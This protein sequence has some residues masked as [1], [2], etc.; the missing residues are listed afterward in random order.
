MLLCS[1]AGRSI[2][3]A[4]SSRSNVSELGEYRALLERA[5]DTIKRLEQRLES[6]ERDYREAIAIVGMGCRY[7]GGVTDAAGYWDLLAS[8]RDG[9]VRVPADRWDAEACYDP[10]PAAPGK[11]NSRFGGFIDDVAVFDAMLFNMSPREAASTDP[12][13]RLMLT[14]AWEALE[15]AGYPPDGLRG[16]RT[17]VFVGINSNDYALLRAGALEAIDAYCGTANIA[18]AAAGRVSYAFGLEGPSLSVD[19]ACSSSLVS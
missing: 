9:V 13:H 8:G 12:Q 16:T 14:M 5:H 2:V 6:A 4:R 15:D 18:S 17:G 19:T 1:F 10:D 7:P 11:T 3:L